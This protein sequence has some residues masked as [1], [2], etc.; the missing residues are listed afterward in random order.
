MGVNLG[1]PNNVSI[2]NNRVLRNIFGPKKE[3]VRGGWR[4][5]L[6]EKVQ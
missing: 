4:K 5:L 2:F 6:N 3:A 1:L